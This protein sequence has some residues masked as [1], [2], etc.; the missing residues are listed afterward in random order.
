M[1]KFGLL[2]ILL[3]A[4]MLASCSGSGENPQESIAET[5]AESLA[6]T[7]EAAEMT[8]VTVSETEKI[9]ENEEVPEPAKEY[10]EVSPNNEFIDF[11]FI[12]DYQGT[13]D[14]G[15][16]ADKAVE[17]LTTTDEYAEA[18]SKI[19][20]ISEVYGETYIKDGKIIPQFN[21]AYPADYDGDGTAETFI[22]VD[23]PI[24]N[25]NNAL[26]SFFIFA[27]SGGNMTLLD[28]NCNVFDT[29]FLNYG[30]YK[31]ITFG[32]SGIIGAGDHIYLYGV[33]DGKVKELYVG[34]GNF[35]KEDCFLSFFGWQGMG[36]FMYFDTAAMEYVGV[37][38][39]TVPEETIREMD[40]DNVFENYY[41]E[42]GNA[43]PETFKLVGNKYY[44]AAMS[45]MDWGSVYV[46]E[47]GKFVYLPDSK[48]RNNN[49]EPEIRTVTDIDIE[50]A[51]ANMKPVQK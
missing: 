37:D 46:Y 19:D 33:A 17:F 4:A 1:K 34:R 6:A 36:S 49:S 35:A 39:V 32:G 18:M 40:A 25:M 9:M 12:E 7:S 15:D 29:L 5:T 16:L 31:Q 44:V 28:H 38:G 11:E 45:V 47:D 10:V 41:S 22:V 42:T 8:T 30:K 50:Q 3:S 24:I 48:V 21:T 27:D 2:G 14:I 26:Y 23:M 51:L 20:E 13:T 43:Y